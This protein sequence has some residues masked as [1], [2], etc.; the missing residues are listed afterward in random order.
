MKIRIGASIWNILN[1]PSFSQPVANI[2]DAN[3]GKIL[4]DDWQRSWG[5]FRGSRKILIIAKFM[6]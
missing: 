3:V 5:P 1:H 6:F 2:R 4:S